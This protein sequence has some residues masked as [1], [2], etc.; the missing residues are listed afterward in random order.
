MDH[1]AIWIGENLCDLFANAFL[2]TTP[3]PGS[4]KEILDKLEFIK[5]KNYTQ[6]KLLSQ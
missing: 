2:G 5:I 6:Q 4:M 3:K 1:K